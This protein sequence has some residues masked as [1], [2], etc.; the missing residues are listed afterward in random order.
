LYIDDTM[1]TSFLEKNVKNF[2][3]K[4]F[5]VI[6]LQLLLIAMAGIL[7]SKSYIPLTIFVLAEILVAAAYAKILFSD[8][9]KIQEKEFW[10]YALFFGGTAAI[11]QAA[12]LFD[13]VEIGISPFQEFA[14]VLAA[15]LVFVVGF[16]II[17]GRKYTEGIVVLS[18]AEMAVVE[19]EFDL[20]SFTN[21]GKHVVESDRPYKKGQKVRVVTEG[22]MF[23]GKPKRIEGLA[24]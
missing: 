2:N 20:L 9:R 4:T 24:K 16:R 12:W 11:I 3:R 7:F 15:F 23:A 10:K 18:D 17:Y 8:L 14:V 13:V 21:A 5:A 22:V 6:L 1:I 19:T